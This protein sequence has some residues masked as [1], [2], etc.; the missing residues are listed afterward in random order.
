MNMTGEPTSTQWARPP[1]AVGVHTEDRRKDL[2]HNRGGP[3]HDDNFVAGGILMDET[4]TWVLLA[5]RTPPWL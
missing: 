5:P 2:D 1:G 3:Q 4:V